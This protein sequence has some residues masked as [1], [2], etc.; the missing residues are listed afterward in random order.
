MQ[1]YAALVLIV[2]RSGV[3]ASTST[4]IH[5]ANLTPSLSRTQ[6]L[7]V[8]SGGTH[9]VWGGSNSIGK[10]FS[11][12]LW[13]TLLWVFFIKASARDVSYLAFFST[14]TSSSW[15]S[16][17]RCVFSVFCINAPKNV[18]TKRGENYRQLSLD[19]FSDLVGGVVVFFT[20]KDR[21]F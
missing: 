5:P 3:A 18:C 16:F 15:S 10:T 20:F 17:A 2:P 14:P 11:R 8:F 12:T 9:L 13:Y 7:E 4:T 19:H 6:P 1:S 21:S